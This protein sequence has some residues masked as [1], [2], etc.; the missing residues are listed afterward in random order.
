MVSRVLET[1]TLQP[2]VKRRRHERTDGSRFTTVELPESVL[3][4]LGTKRV[5]EAIATWARGEEKRKTARDRLRRVEELLRDGV[6]PTAIAH[7]L[8]I[9]DQRV[10]QIRK[11][12][13]SRDAGQESA[14]GVA[15]P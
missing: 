1:R 10:K 3:R 13:R 4:S 14:E 15:Q 9:T 5:D 12:L 7:E 8:G 11:A 2:G 6:K